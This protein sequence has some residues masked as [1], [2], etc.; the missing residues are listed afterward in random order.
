MEL[1]Y[2]IHC[3]S[4]E[5]TVC[6][7]ERKLLQHREIDDTVEFMLVDYE[8]N[9]DYEVI[10]VGIDGRARIQVESGGDYSSLCDETEIVEHIISVTDILMYNPNYFLYKIYIPEKAV[11][12]GA[13]WMAVDLC[14]DGKVDKISTNS[15]YCYHSDYMEILDSVVMLSEPDNF[16]HGSA[17][18]IVFGVQID[19]INLKLEMVV[20]STAKSARSVQ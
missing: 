3:F 15:R 20:R 9:E 11:T 16:Q 6:T 13:E 12:F 5:R 7:V 1:P 18:E 4:P 14:G 19:G 10:D 8:D 2:E 17:R